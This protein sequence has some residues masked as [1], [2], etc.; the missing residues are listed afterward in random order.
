MDVFCPYCGSEQ[1]I[2]H[3]DGF[4]YEEDVRHEMQCSECEKNFV[5]TTSI[6]YDYKAEK[7]DCLN[8]NNHKYIL[9]H[10]SPKELST[11]RCEYCDDSRELTDSERIKFGIGT[12][13]SYFEKRK[14]Y[15]R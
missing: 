13:E 8:N 3:D 4:G 15:W 6:S 1:E 9:T 11:M 12:I 2:N 5:F 7:A 14:Q 10:T